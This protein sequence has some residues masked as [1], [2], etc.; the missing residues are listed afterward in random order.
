M[1]KLSKIRNDG[2]TKELGNR[3]DQ[4]AE[5]HLEFIAKKKKEGT[6]SDA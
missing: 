6:A 3:G 4:N 2:M 5:S 1:N